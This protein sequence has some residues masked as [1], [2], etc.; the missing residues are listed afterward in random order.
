MCEQCKRKGTR[1]HSSEPV[2]LSYVIACPQV[3]E[4]AH[5][6]D[7]PYRCDFPSCGKA[8]ATGNA[9]GWRLKVDHFWVRAEL[10]ELLEGSPAQAAVRE[11]AV[12]IPAFRN[13]STGR[14]A[15]DGRGG[16]VRMSVGRPCLSVSAEGTV[17]SLGFPVL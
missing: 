7:R 4:R 9:S 2:L 8:F 1:E 12:S 10:W 14:P 13:S 5:T 16:T 6:G 17:L 3:H 11:T 15:A